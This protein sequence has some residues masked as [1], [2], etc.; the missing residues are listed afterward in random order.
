[1]DV[2]NIDEDIARFVVGSIATG[3]MLRQVAEDLEDPLADD[4][5]TEEDP[6]AVVLEML[7]NDFHRGRLGGSLRAAAGDGAHRSCR[8]ADAGASGAGAGDVGSDAP[9]PTEGSVAPMAERRQRSPTLGRPREVV[10]TAEFG[11]WFQGVSADLRGK[12]GSVIDH[13][14][15]VGPTLG[16]PTW[17]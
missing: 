2:P 14:V 17:T 8:H 10:K 5:Y 1:M 11:R 13:I 9:L 3:A 15:E 12:V 4:A 16:R 7:W 6:R